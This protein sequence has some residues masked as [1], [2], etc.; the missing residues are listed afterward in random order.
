MTSRSTLPKATSAICGRATRPGFRRWRG[1]AETDRGWR[2]RELYAPYAR[3]THAD[4]GLNG[5]IKLLTA[6]ALSPRRLHARGGASPISE[7]TITLVVPF[8]AGGSNDIFARA[9]G[10]KL[11]ESWQVPVVIENQAGASGALGAAR[12]AKADPDGH[13]LLIVSSTYTINAAVQPSPL[14]DAGQSFAA[15]SLLGQGP[16]MLAVSKSVPAKD[17]K[18]LLNSLAGSPANSIMVRPELAASTTWRW[19]CSRALLVSTSS[20]CPI[21]L[22]ICGQRSRR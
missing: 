9:I 10:Q 20:M 6:L 21:D 18:E 13:T 14:F 3:R 2:H 4:P 22:V 16:L 8:A 19:S 1:I 5:N 15:V 17:A 12:V 11:N 7:Q